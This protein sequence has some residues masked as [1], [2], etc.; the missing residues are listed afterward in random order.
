M[1][2]W[3]NSLLGNKVSSIRLGDEKLF[4][5]LLLTKFMSA[6]P[7]VVHVSGVARLGSI[8]TIPRLTRSAHLHSL[9]PTL[10]LLCVQQE[11]V[12]SG[13]LGF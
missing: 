7:L 4:G 6:T 8:F 5:D 3:P 1:T 11:F 12:H 13:D 9:L 2:S 10:T